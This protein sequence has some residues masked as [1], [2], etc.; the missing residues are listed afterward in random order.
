M[1]AA[2]K[3]NAYFCTCQI[4]LLSKHQLYAEDNQ[5]AYQLSQNKKSVA[6]RTWLSW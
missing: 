4:A 6:L 2:R 1:M 5:A 3:C